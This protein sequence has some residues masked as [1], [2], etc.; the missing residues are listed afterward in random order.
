VTDGTGAEGDSGAGLVPVPIVAQWRG[1]GGGAQLAGGVGD[2]TGR[3]STSSGL[4]VAHTVIVASR[5]ARLWPWPREQPVRGLVHPPPR[6]QHRQK[7]RREHHVAIR[8]SLAVDAE[9]HPLAI[10]GGDR[11]PDGFE[12]RR[13]AA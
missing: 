11:E 13:P 12:I 2:G 4:T 8:L 10:D 7:R 6:A 5:S 3:G 1:L 9:D